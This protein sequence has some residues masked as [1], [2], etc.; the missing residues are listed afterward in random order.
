MKTNFDAIEFC[1]ALNQIPLPYKYIPLTRGQYAIVDSR[2]FPY[3]NQ[4]SWNAKPDGDSYYAERSSSKD[5]VDFHV[6]MH[7]AIWERHNGPIPNGMKLDHKDR[8]K[9][10]DRIRN[11]RLL[12]HSENVSN[13]DKRPGMSSKFV[14]VHY[15]KENGNYRAQVTVDGNQ[16]FLGAFPTQQ[17]ASNARDNYVRKHQAKGKIINNARM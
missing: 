8:N 5:N 17:E 2:D 13:A 9:L 15:N 16:M 10:N 6:A 14:G 12:S 1:K 7:R 4:W 11:M 3:L